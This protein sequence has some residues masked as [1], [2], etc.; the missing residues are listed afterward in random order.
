MDYRDKIA[1]QIKE[2]LKGTYYESYTKGQIILAIRIL[3][4]RIYRSMVRGESFGFKKVM[5]IFPD[6]GSISARK[7][8]RNI[9]RRRKYRQSIIAS[10]KRHYFGIRLDR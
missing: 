10:R 1:Q 4:G 9:K 5:S 7:V 6:P 3:E 8:M 2:D